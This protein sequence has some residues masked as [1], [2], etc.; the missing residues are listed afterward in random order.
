MADT[1]INPCRYLA[2]GNTDYY[3]Y[4]IGFLNA[5]WPFE[6]WRFHHIAG[7]WG[8]RGIEI[9]VDGALHGVGAYV[10]DPSN[11]VQDG[12]R[13]C[14]PQELALSPIYPDCNAPRPG[15]E[16]IEYAGGLPPYATFLVGCRPGG[17]CFR[18][19]IDEVRIS[20]IQRN[21]NFTVVPTVT[22]TPT[23]TPSPLTGGYTVDPY[24]SRLYHLDEKSPGD[25]GW[26]IEASGNNALFYNGPTLVPGRFGNAY[27][28]SNGS[29]FGTGDAGN[30]LN[31]TLEGWINL[32]NVASPFAVISVLDGG[33][34]GKE[35]LR[36]FWGDRP[37]HRQ[38]VLAW[39]AEN[40]CTGRTAV[41]NQFNC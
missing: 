30:F 25:H 41:S 32:D 4:G 11:Y 33:K 10:P 22:P 29:Y 39:I 9:W 34:W 3:F 12:A 27:H 13:S 24:T 23:N 26:V 28:L 17:S 6:T 19:R 5:P 18:G 31:T 35:V 16:P 37:A 36:R 38:F 40:L 2:G 14:G 21:F 15:F 1:G 20:N 7:T 8:P